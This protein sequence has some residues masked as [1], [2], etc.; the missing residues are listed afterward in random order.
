MKKVYDEVVEESSML[1]IRVE[2]GVLPG[3]AGKE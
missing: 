1:R 3:A 2:P